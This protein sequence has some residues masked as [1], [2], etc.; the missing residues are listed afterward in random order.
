MSRAGVFAL[1]WTATL[2]ASIVNQLLVTHLLSGI[3]D[4]ACCNE[5]FTLPI[6]TFVLCTGALLLLVLLNV[7]MRPR[8]HEDI[9]GASDTP[10]RR[11]SGNT[12]IIYVA[13]MLFAFWASVTMHLALLQTQRSERQRLAVS[14]LP[15]PFAVLLLALSCLLAVEQFGQHGLLPLSL[16][17]ASRPLLQM[18]GP[19]SVVIMMHVLPSSSS[20]SSS[21]VI[22]NNNNNNNS[23]DE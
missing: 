4:S 19:D 15:A 12:Q 16:S 22:N 3:Y 20:S 8:K 23:H 7:A 6:V 9:R 1:L 10:Q 21:L 2:L 18:L 13:Y 17:L 11:V 14:V 5:S